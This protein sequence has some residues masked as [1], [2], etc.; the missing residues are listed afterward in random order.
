MQV[1]D[2]SITDRQTPFFMKLFKHLTKNSGFLQ[3][4]EANNALIRVKNTYFCFIQ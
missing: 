1:F 3:V 2:K 4:R